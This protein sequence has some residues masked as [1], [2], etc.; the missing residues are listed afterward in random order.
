MICCE[1]NKQEIQIEDYG[2]WE[3]E[4]PHIEYQASVSLRG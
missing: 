4:R 2:G 3:E 1:E